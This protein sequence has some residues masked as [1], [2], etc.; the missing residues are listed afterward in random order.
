MLG[1]MITYRIVF[2]HPAPHVAQWWPL[3]YQVMQD[4]LQ[5]EFTI[6]IISCDAEKLLK[7]GQGAGVGKQKSK[8]N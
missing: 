7:E 4:A 6:K 2:V 8:R 1:T 3:L 5:G